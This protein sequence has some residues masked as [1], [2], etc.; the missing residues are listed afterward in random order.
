M[1]RSEDINEFK[2]LM[3]L[4]EK[5]KATI[6]KYGT[7]IQ[8]LKEWLGD[9]ELSK[10]LLLEYREELLKSHKPQT[11]NGKLS[12]VNAYLEF[13]QI[14]EMRVSF[15]KIQRQP[16]LEDNRELSEI[17]YKR[18]LASAL[19]KGNKRLYLLMMTLGSTGIRISELTYITVETARAGRVQIQMKGKCRTILLPKQL[20]KN[21]LNY[22]KEKKIEEGMIF[23]TRNG[24]QMDR[25][26]IWH[27]I[28]SLC[29]EA[30]VN[31]E[32]VFPHNFRHL[33]ARVFYAIEKNLAYLADVLGHSSIETTRIY[34]ATSVTAHQKILSKMKL[35]E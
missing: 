13:K 28:K 20:C 32:K 10:E 17:E 34:V 15:L 22:S 4:N 3:K 31:K 29:S 2:K 19:K 11:V 25:S 12:A 5:S 33:F 21:L 1:I 35:V 30:K 24:R 16:F 23:R 14:P 7:T 6:Q 26:N 9:R 27:E 18:L 8:K